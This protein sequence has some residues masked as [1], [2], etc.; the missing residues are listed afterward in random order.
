MRQILIASV[1]VVIGVLGVG[2]RS[3]SSGKSSRKGE[4]LETYD[5][6][7]DPTTVTIKPG[8]KV[9]LAIKNEGKREHNFS[10]SSLGISKDIEKGGASTVTFTAPSASGDIQFFCKY[11]KASNNMVGTLH[12]A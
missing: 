12:V 8:A 11:H 6:R 4:R 2:C 3:S 5:F 1:V 10:V 9:T 7:F